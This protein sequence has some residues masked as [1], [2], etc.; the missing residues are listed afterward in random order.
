[1]T[2]RS[3]VTRQASQSAHQALQQSRPWIERLARLGY[4]TKGLV[5]AVVG[6]LALQATFSTVKQTAGTSGALQTIA[7]QPLGIFLIGVIALGLCGYA[8]WRFIAAVIDPDRKGNDAKGL[9]Q[10]AGY[11]ISGI[12]HLGLAF[13]AVQ[14]LF[15]SGGGN[16]GDEFSQSWAARIMSQP[17]GNWLVGIA[18]AIIIGYGLYEFY[19]AYKAK[20]RTE[21][22]LADMNETAEQ[23]AIRSGRAGLAARG[24]VFCIIG[25]FLIQATLQADPSEMKG[26]D[27][28]LQMLEQQPF[29]PWLLGTV[30][31]GLVA[32]GAFM[33][34]MA[35]Y[36]R[37]D[38]G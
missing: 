1:M 29:G 32:Y 15:G 26:M 7:Q 11:V 34:I 13:T 17:F 37:I 8:L 28:A 4:A 6:L 24:V 9:I 16:S 22:N 25:G 10:R 5:Y 31:L 14:I 23:T 30:A 33:V 27:S 3:S 38:V 12:I 21:L 36:S 35:R 19:A 18:G 2:Q 20:F